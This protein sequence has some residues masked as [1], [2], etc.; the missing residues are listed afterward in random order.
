MARSQRCFGV[1]W[2]EAFFSGGAL[3]S[4]SSSLHAGSTKG[5]ALL[6][7]SLHSEAFGLGTFYEDTTR[8][9]D[10]RQAELLARTPEEPG[11]PAEDTSGVIHLAVKFDW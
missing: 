4:C 7:L 11:E 2:W 1:C 5:P 10:A 3:V 9:L 6:C 8:E